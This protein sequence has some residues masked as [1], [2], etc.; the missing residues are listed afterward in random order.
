[1][2]VQKLHIGNIVK[3]YVLKNKVNTSE[4]ARKV[5]KTRQNLYDF[6]KREDVEVKLLL[7]IS[8]ALEHDFFE[9]IKPSKKNADID[10]IFDVL[11]E[12]VKERM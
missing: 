7:A 8:E 4:L 5:G 11:K 6:Y 2:S 3:D 10:K 9:D 12:V 1:M